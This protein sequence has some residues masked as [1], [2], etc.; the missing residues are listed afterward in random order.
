MG[1]TTDVGI[2]AMAPKAKPKAKGKALAKAAPGPR[3]RWRSGEEVDFHEIAL[4]D[5]GRGVKI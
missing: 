4:E 1:T 5:L 2:G 3:D